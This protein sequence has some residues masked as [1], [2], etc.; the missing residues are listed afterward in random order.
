[1]LRHVS[2]LAVG[3]LQGACKFF[4]ACAAY[5]STYMVGI[6]R[7]IKIIVMKIKYHTS[8]SVRRMIE[9]KCLDTTATSTRERKE[10]R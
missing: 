4:L 7:M 9:R 1:M 3:H 2:A 6:L 8:Y 10:E 5:A